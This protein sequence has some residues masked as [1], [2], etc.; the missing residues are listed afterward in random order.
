MHVDDLGQVCYC[1]VIKLTLT[2][3]IVLVNAGYKVKRCP[4]HQIERKGVKISYVRNET[5]V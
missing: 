2:Q 4:L 3:L 5:C 1:H